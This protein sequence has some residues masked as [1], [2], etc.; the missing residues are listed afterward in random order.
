MTESQNI[1]EKSKIDIRETAPRSSAEYETDMNIRI[2]REKQRAA[3]SKL[4]EIRSG[5]DT[6]EF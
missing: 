3:V 4:R 6:I 1:V 2:Q 5:W